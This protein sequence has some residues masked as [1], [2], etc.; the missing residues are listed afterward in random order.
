MAPQSPTDTLT[1]PYTHMVFQSVSIILIC[2]AYFPTNIAFFDFI[3]GACI[4]FVLFFSIAELAALNHIVVLRQ[5]QPQ[6]NTKP[7]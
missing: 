6:P 1:D 5:R 2:F 7:Q 4:L 3:Q